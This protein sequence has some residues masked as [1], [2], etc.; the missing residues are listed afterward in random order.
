MDY[1]PDNP[2]F[3]KSGDNAT[4][5]DVSNG[6]LDPVH[7]ASDF[8]SRA[9]TNDMAGNVRTVDNPQSFLQGLFRTQ[10]QNKFNPQIQNSLNGIDQSMQGINQQEGVVNQNFSDAQQSLQEKANQLGL[11]SSGGTAALTNKTASDKA[12]AL[13]TLALQRAGLIN[14]KAAVN[15]QG[16]QSIQDMVDQLLNNGTANQKSAFDR[17]VQLQQISATIPKG[18]TVNIQGQMITGTMAPKYSTVDLGNRTAVMDENGNVVKSYARGAVP[19]SGGGAT[20]EESKFQSAL[21]TAI[22]SGMYTSTGEKGKMSREQLINTLDGMFTGNI[23]RTSIAAAVYSQLTHPGDFTYD[24]S[25]DKA[26]TQA[27]QQNQNNNAVAQKAL[28]DLSA[29]SAA[30]NK[31]GSRASLDYVK[32]VKSAFLAA[33]TGSDVNVT[34][35]GLQG[36]AI[37]TAVRALLNTGRITTAEIDAIQLPTIYD[38]KTQAQTKLNALQ[39]LLNTSGGGSTQTNTT[40]MSNIWGF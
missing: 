12:S 32:Q 10:A 38:T 24:P 17:Q 2:R 21:S 8:L 25:K 40:S 26:Q 22:K 15:T 13:A 18:Q 19:T 6:Y 16:Q 35:M 37:L 31:S 5:F 1:N 4:V 7:G 34:K 20:A 33:Q 27:E 23:P 11:L 30:I 3:I 9:G 14:Q 39:A 29:A 28:S 36:Q